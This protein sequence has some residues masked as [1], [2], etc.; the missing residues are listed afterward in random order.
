[1]NSFRGLMTTNIETAK[2]VI[3]GLPFDGNASVGKGASLAPAQLR[4]L[5]A[6]LPPATRT[7]TLIPACLYDLGDAEP[8]LEG[9]AQLAKQAFALNKFTIFLGGDH[10]VNIATIPTFIEL[11]AQQNKIPVLIHL[12]AHPDIC[13]EYKGNYYSH[14]TPV[15]RAID[16]GIATE[17]VTLVGIRGYEEQEIIYFAAHPEIRVIRADEVN[18]R[19]IAAVIEEIISKYGSDQYAI[20]LSY[21]I[22]ANDPAFAPGTGTPEAFGL[23]NLDTLTFVSELISRLN[24][25]ALDLVEV[26]PPLDINDITSW[27]ALKTLYEVFAIVAGKK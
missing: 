5:S 13:D 12:D 11:C 18:K 19:G 9:I 15:K 10:S 26:S 20:Y 2:I 3:A 7:G 17:N 4:A 16:N 23:T 22:D 27:L 14:A 21:D 25:L 6:H 8:T 1:M 24:V